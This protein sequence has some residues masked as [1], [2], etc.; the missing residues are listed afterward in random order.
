MKGDLLDT[1]WPEVDER[2]LVSATQSLVVQ[3]N[4]K[5]RGHVEIRSEA[6]E[7]EIREAVL[8]DEKIAR[9]IGDHDVRKVIVVPGKLVN[10]VI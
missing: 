6:D 7:S 3:V 9:H 2:A 10:V 8:S 4:G 5:L 1:P